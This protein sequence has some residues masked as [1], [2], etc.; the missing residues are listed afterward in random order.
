MALKAHVNPP[1]HIHTFL[2][3]LKPA[4]GQNGWKPALWEWNR[5][6]TEA[7]MKR[8][9]QVGERLHRSMSDKTAP[10][11]DNKCFT[12]PMILALDNSGSCCF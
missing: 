4:Q 12:Q 6:E 1:Q 3:Y 2:G 7:K 9:S 8:S 5:E 11:Q 10:Q